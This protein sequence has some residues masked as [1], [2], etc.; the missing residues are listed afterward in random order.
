MAMFSGSFNVRG[1][2]VWLL[3][4]CLA[5][6]GCGGST[7]RP[8]M[9]AVA[10]KVT[11]EGAAVGEGK[12]A[13]FDPS[14]GLGG[15]GALGSDGSYKLEAPAGTYKVSITPPMQVV[16]AG[17]NS[18]PSEEY[19]KVDNIPDRYRSP[20]SSGLSATIS[21]D[22]LTHDFTLTKKK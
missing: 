17:P 8:A 12:V 5:L 20:D 22:K 21:S 13:F 16:D 11:F 9:L 2:S 7:E 19:K 1:N 18:P 15:E 6:A 4:F 14:T 10:G 3:V